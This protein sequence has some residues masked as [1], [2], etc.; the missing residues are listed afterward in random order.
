MLHCQF[1]PFPV[2]TTERL[3]LRKFRVTDQEA[4]FALRSNRE[5]MQY[6]DRPM[7]TSLADALKYIEL[8]I[9]SADNN[10]GIT[11][12]ITLK[13][14]DVLIGT[15]GFWKF[16]KDNHRAEIGYMLHPDY[17]RRGIM[18][19]ALGAIIPY[20][21]DTIRLHSIEAN[22]NPANAASIAILEKNKFAREA[23]FR[24]NYYY[25]GRFLDSAIYSRLCHD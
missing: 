8:I 7:A 15:I 17:H 1:N 13:E 22:V 9:T 6:L 25:N 21:F 23:Y 24:E 12:A 2:I 16:D 5:A 10:E 4:V 3:L 20:G 11:W 14:E 19:E 18:Q